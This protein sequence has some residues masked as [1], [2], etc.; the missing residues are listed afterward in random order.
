MIFSDKISH[1]LNNNSDSENLK[2]INENGTAGQQ[3]DPFSFSALHF[4][5]NRLMPTGEY[6]FENYYI[7]EIFKKFKVKV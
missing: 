1:S 2:R 5:R 4:I 6:F 7:C 3:I